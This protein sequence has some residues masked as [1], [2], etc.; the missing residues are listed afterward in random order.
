MVCVCGERIFVSFLQYDR[1]LVTPRTEKRINYQPRAAF[2]SGGA[3]FVL[4]LGN[5][6]GTAECFLC[7][8]C[9]W[10]IAGKEEVHG[11]GHARKN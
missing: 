9:V 11:A 4:A 10:H 3:S 5:S 6:R 7:E 1:K 8:Q 2:G